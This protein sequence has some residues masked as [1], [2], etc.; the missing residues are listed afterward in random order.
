[1]KIFDVI[2]GDL[3][4]FY[5]K[6]GDRKFRATLRD[7]ALRVEDFGGNFIKVVAIPGETSVQTVFVA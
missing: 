7:G 4:V 5:D 6:Q 2:E 3:V 1:M